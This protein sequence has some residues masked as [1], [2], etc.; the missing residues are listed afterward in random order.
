MPGA[1]EHVVGTDNVRIDEFSGTRNRAVDVALS[2]KM[3][4]PLWSKCRHRL[5]NHGEIAYVRFQ[6]A[7]TW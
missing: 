6:E 7:V 4:D 2:G 5:L 1:F 3:H